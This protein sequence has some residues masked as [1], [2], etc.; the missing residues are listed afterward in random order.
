MELIRSL[1]SGRCSTPIQPYNMFMEHSSK[2]FLRIYFPSKSTKSSVEAMGLPH[3]ASNGELAAPLIGAMIAFAMYG[4]LIC[5]T[6]WYFRAFPKDP[7]YLKI[8]IVLLCASE[9]AGLVLDSRSIWYYFIRRGIGVDPETLISCN[10]W[11]AAAFFVP[12]E[13]TCFLVEVLFIK[14]MW[15]LASKKNYI[16]AAVVLVPFLIGWGFTIYFLQGILRH[17]C[18]PQRK[19]TNFS[20]IMSFGMRV[21]SSGVVTA[22]MCILLTRRAVPLSS[23]KMVQTEKMLRVVHYLVLGSLSTGFIMWCIAIS[24]MIT[25]I[26]LSDSPVPFGIYNVR[27][28]FFANA[29]LVSLNDRARYRRILTETIPLRS[30][31]IVLPATIASCSTKTPTESSPQRSDDSQT[32]GTSEMA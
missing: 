17:F 29:V 3:A 22:T 23:Y 26:I 13:F 20:L 12:T 10:Y 30:S 5:Q 9:T 16:L 15:S 31:E 8:L 2:S 25:Y 14:R 18:A 6:A 4:A 1:E 28:S 7:L 19:A 27:G 32:A 21:F 11:S 24:F